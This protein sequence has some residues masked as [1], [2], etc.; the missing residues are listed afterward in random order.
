[1]SRAK[2]FELWFPWSPEVTGLT[3]ED[4]GRIHNRPFAQVLA[5]ISRETDWQCRQVYFTQRKRGYREEHEGIENLLFPVS[6]RRLGRSRQGG[7]QLSF[8]A[9]KYLGT[10]P[11]GC[12]AFFQAH[13]RFPQ[14]GAQICEKRG[15]PYIVIIGAWYAKYNESLARYFGGAHRLLAHTQMQLD[16]L[17]ELGH[18]RH[19]MEVFPIGVDTNLFSPPSQASTRLHPTYPKLL[20]V[21][22]MYPFKGAPQALQSFATVRQRYENATLRMVGPPG[23]LASMQSMQRFIQAHD[24]NDA[25]S[26]ETA[27]DHCSLPDIYRE[28]DLL[29]YP[30]MYEG[31]PQ[32]V[33]E[34][35]ASGTPVLAVHGEAGTAEVIDHAKDSWIV[36]MPDLT[37]TLIEILEDRERLLLAG[38]R[39]SAKIRERY[40]TERH[41]HQIRTIF[42]EIDALS[43]QGQVARMRPAITPSDSRRR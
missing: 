31:L 42:R 15:I 35:M 7:R 34:S 14:L 13:G 26:I 21:G 27:V 19:N 24:L 33:L 10:A 5:R 41:F 2:T 25:V 43:K 40:S 16:A 17:V 39:A 6:L 30:S 28:A 38:E 8:A 3:E 18:S 12:V 9:L 22:R 37:Y 1:M 4:L 29:L 20:Y 36:N 32:V 23:D 11:L